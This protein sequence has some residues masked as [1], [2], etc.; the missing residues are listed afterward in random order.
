MHDA[1]SCEKLI[2]IWNTAVTGDLAKNVRISDYKNHILFLET[3]NS[4]WAQQ[5]VFVKQMIIDKLAELAPNIKITDIKSRAGNFNLETQAEIAPQELSEQDKKSMENILT[6]VE[7]V[8]Q[9]E[10]L[11]K[12]LEKE[13][14]Y[15]QQDNRKSCPICEEKF[16]GTGT[17][18][19]HCQSEHLHT[20]DVKIQDYL[21]EAPWSRFQDIKKDYD[22]VD[23]IH[24][25]IVKDKLINK[26][27]DKIQSLYYENYETKKANLIQELRKR[28][29]L[30]VSLKTGLTPDKIQESVIIN[31]IGKKMYGV[32]FKK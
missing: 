13:M 9:K 30:F 18:C 11:S 12:I 22:N 8:E 4:T 10:K 24:Y 17:I 23:E 31:E 14:L 25:H 21:V 28:I 3:K 29:F 15:R 6:Q 19:L 32:V 1:L 2:G 20:E 7:D 16:E 27:R 26:T 5:L